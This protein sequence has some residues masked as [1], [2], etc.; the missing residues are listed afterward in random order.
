MWRSRAH[1]ATVE[2]TV[3]RH[4]H[5]LRGEGV[6]VRVARG[7]GTKAARILHVL[8]VPTRC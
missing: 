3:D 2:P 6:C 5:V 7:L 8:A 1:N 4:M